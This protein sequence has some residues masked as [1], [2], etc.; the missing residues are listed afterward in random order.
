MHRH[1]WMKSDAV[2]AGCL[3]ADWAV[4]SRIHAVATTRR[5]PGRSLP[6]FDRCNLGVRSGDDPALVMENR[7]ALDDALALPSRPVWLRQVHGTDVL[8]IDEPLRIPRAID[9][10]PVADAAVTSTRGVVLAIQ[11]ADCLPVLM[12]ADD[13]TCI[14]AAH[15]GWRGLRDGVLE[16]TVRAMAAAPDQLSAWLGP[17][18]GAGSYEVGGEVRDA[19]LAD[20]RESAACFVPTRPGHWRCDLHAL[21]RLRLARSGVTRVQGGGFDTFA[22]SGRFHS[23]R[24]DGAASGRQATLIWIGAVPGV[25]DSA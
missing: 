18:I 11:T 9:D 3:P 23:Y 25:A 20:G 12:A 17:A 10:E 8:A 19:F 1:A 13:G 16:R 2:V 21:A 24:R 5:A 7:R 4:H 22:D 6:P 14:G 15:A